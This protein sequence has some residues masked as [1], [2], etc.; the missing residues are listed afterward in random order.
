VSPAVVR[1]DSTHHH[2]GRFLL[3]LLL[4]LV[5]NDSRIHEIWMVPIARA[6]AVVA[7]VLMVVVTMEE[8]VSVASYSLESVVV[9]TTFDGKDSE[10][11]CLESP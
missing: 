3:L 1:V 4:P 9:E 7:V 8:V 5:Q 6:A 11:E 10:T 2:H